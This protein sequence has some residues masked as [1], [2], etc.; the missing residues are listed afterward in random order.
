MLPK[1]L[2]SSRFYS[3]IQINTSR[4]ARRPAPSTWKDSEANRDRRQRKVTGQQGA[5]C[6]VCYFCATCGIF[7]LSLSEGD[8]CVKFC[9]SEVG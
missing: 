2:A 4:R 7:C 9:K 6:H 3:L 1:R 5:L 8:V